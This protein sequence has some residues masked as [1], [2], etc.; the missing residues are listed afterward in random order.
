VE[1]LRRGLYRYQPVGHRLCF[2]FDSD[3]LEDEL[4]EA[5][6]GQKWNSAATFVWTTVPYRM[7]W[8]YALIAH[9]LIAI[10]VGHVC[11][12]LYL[13]CESIA[14]GTCAIGAYDQQKLDRVLRVDGQEEFAIY[15]APVGRARD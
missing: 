5:L 4:D 8:R 6:L 12:N 3:T 1:S 7:E 2:L 13:A 14:C 15:A 9:K 11:Q 10:D